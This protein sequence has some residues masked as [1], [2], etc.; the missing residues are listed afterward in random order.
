VENVESQINDAGEIL[1]GSEAELSVQALS[2]G[3][4][5]EG[6]CSENRKNQIALDF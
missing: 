2:S 1:F 6:Q 4:L 5:S 3:T